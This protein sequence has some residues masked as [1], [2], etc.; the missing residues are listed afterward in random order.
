MTLKPAEFV[1]TQV[2]LRKESVDR[3]YPPG[4]PSFLSGV[5]LSARRAW[6]EIIEADKICK[7]PVKVALRKESVDR[8]PYVPLAKVRHCEVALRKESV[9]RNRGHGVWPRRSVWSLSARRAWIEILYT[10][11]TVSWVPCRSPQGE[12]G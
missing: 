1:P 4:P 12:R 7:P 2:A 3:N 5:S 9:D 6:I 8:N 11:A 10:S